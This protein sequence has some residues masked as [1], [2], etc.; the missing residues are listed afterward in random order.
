MSYAVCTQALR[1]SDSLLSCR[2]ALL[3]ENGECIHKFYAYLPPFLQQTPAQTRF[4]PLDQVSVHSIDDVTNDPR[5]PGRPVPA[6]VK[7]INDQ[8]D[9]VE[10]LNT[11]IREIK[12]LIKVN[13]DSLAN[14]IRWLEFEHLKKIIKMGLSLSDEQGDIWLERVDEWSDAQR[15]SFITI[16]NVLTLIGCWTTIFVNDTITHGYIV[17]DKEVI[18]IIIVSG[19]THISNIKHSD[20][21]PCGQHG[22]KVLIVSRDRDDRPINPIA[23]RKFTEA[24]DQENIKYCSYHAMKTCLEAS[25][26]Q[27]FIDRIMSQVGF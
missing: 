17:H 11:E 3:R 2:D 12:Q 23:D 22:R 14:S 13:H 8:L 7:W 5:T 26:E 1:G 10:Y 24:H 9:T 21:I 27:E 25:T 4:L 20:D 15:D 19:R 6:I 18:D 16:I